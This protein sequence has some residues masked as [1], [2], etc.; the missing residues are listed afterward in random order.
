MTLSPAETCRK[1]ADII[2]YE[3]ERFSMSTWE[4]TEDCGIV[5][6]I[7]GHVALLHQDGKAANRDAGVR[8][9]GEAWRERQG[10]RLGLNK[11]ASSALF[12]PSSVLWRNA[13]EKEGSIRYSRVLRQ[14]EKELEAS[15]R[16]VGPVKLKRIVAEAL[17]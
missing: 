6:C 9:P 11:Q 13:P 3:N 1:V 8:F 5:A 15:E 10:S 16:I 14:L 7:A 17:A 2:D 4:T 12:N